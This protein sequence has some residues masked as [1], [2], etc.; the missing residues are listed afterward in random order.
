MDPAGFFERLD[1]TS[2]E[3]DLVALGA[4]LEPATLVAAY[5]NGC[6]PWPHSGRYA[7]SLERQARRLARSGSVPL[8]PGGKAHR[9]LPWCSP[10]PRAILLTDRLTPSRSLRQRLRHCGWH[11]TMNT[12]FAEVIGGCADR[13]ETWISP[14]MASAYCRLHEEGHAYS[15]EVWAEDGYLVGGLY[16]VLTG[17]VFSGESMFHR[18]SDAAKVAVVA[19]A[20]RLLAAGVVVLDTQQAT[21]HMAALGQVA[22]RRHEYVTVLRA[23][24]D[25]RAVVDTGFHDVA[26]LVS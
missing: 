24:R 7:S 18:R 16:G 6:F 17:R 26:G 12:A 20:A 13:D 8:V 10:D 5:R 1:V 19:L 15:L 11:T 3:Q 2:A 9:L 22:V 4:D 14:A 23:L 25:E 21:P